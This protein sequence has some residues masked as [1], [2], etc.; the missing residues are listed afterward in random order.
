MFRTD[1]GS[2]S[3]RGRGPRFER[4]S[5]GETLAKHYDATLKDLLEADP[6]AWLEFLHVG[7]T[8]PIRVIDSDLATVTAAADKVLLRD[9][10]APSLIHIEF[11]VSHDLGLPRRLLWYN[12]LLDY[13][14][15][16]PV[17]SVAV[18][19]RPEANSPSFDGRISRGL[20]GELDHLDF[21]YSVVRLWEQPVEPLLEG[22]LG[23]LPLAPISDVDPKRLP[24]ILRRVGERLDAEAKPDRSAR[25]LAATKI[26]MGIRQPLI[27]VNELFQEVFGMSFRV[28]GIEESS[29]ARDLIDKGIAQGMAQGITQGIAQVLTSERRLIL[30][31]G[32]TRFGPPSQEVIATFEG[33][34]D[35][36][37]LE[38]LG[39]R[40]LV[41]TSWDELLAE[42]GASTEFQG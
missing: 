26:L 39:M 27:A 41:V 30:N 2:G 1:V 5:G 35:P 42:S 7:P 25:L 18:L 33:I 37:R 24:D 19:L 28:Y 13:R 34:D 21:R 32:R 36:E 12:V 15:D 23:T 14:H 31:Q 17:L 40:L 4:R 22:P 6:S 8:G 10:Q 9:G 29:V 20:S 38:A 11:Q 3:S 16:L